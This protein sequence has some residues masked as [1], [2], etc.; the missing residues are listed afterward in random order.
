MPTT[1]GSVTPV[2]VSFD[3]DHDDDLRRLLIGQARNK[4]TPF[5]FQ[6]WSLKQAS[7]SWRDEARQRIKRSA[8]VIVICGL[9][10]RSAVG[11]AHEVAIAREEHVPFWLLRGRKDGRCQFPSGTYW[12]WHE[13]HDWTWANIESISRKKTI[14]WW[15]RL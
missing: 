10:T 8:V 15:Q 14:P 3:Y 5:A 13:M 9:H 4:K 11:V 2:F 6:D 12:W 7:P 1:P